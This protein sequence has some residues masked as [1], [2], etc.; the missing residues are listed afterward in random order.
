MPKLITRPAAYTT[1]PYSKR[2]EYI[3]QRANLFHNKP[4]FWLKGW[5]LL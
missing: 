3:K 4:E 2:M 5:E 1:L